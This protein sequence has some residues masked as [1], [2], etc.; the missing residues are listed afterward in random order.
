MC[1]PSGPGKTPHIT[2]RKVKE[3]L[4]F[5]KANRALGRDGIDNETLRM[6]KKILITPLT[7]FFNC[8][9]SSG[10]SLEQWHLSEIILIYKQGDRV[11]LKY[12]RP[13]SPPSNVS[14][15]FMKI[16]KRKIYNILDSQQPV[17]QAGFQ[18]N[19]ST[20]DHIETLSQI[21]EKSKKF[22]KNIAFM[23]V[24]FYEAF[25]S[26]YHEVIWLTLQKR[27]FPLGY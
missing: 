16:I 8:T 27:G 7:A 15:T 18:K 9:L 2:E 14:K 25:D 22:Q 5:L 17:E 1:R 6:F 4:G 13:I 12:Y 19:F 21:F 23:F 10:L 26:L 20:V 3:V 11:D 24:D